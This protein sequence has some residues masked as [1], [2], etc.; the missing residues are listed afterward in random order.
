VLRNESLINNEMCRLNDFAWHLAHFNPY[1]GGKQ[2]GRFING[3]TGRK[4]GGFSKWY[5]TT[6]EQRKRNEFNDAIDEYRKHAPRS[7]SAL[8]SRY[9]FNGNS[10]YHY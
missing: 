2:I 1:E 3:I 5:H 8:P 9:V 7:T 4:S 10:R 6:P